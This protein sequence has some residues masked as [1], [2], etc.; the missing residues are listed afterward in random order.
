M[1][2]SDILRE[3]PLPD[4]WDK[5]VYNKGNKGGFKARIEYAKQKAQKIG[6]GSSRIAFIVEYQGRKTVLKIAKNNKGLAQNE[7]ERYMLY[8][9]QALHADGSVT[10]P[11]IDYDETADKPSWLHVE[12]APKLKNEQQ[13]EQLSGFNMEK[14]INYAGNLTHNRSLP[15]SHRMEFEKE[16]TQKVWENEESFSYDFVS[17]VGNCELHLPDLLRPANWGVFNNRP[18]II[19]LGLSEEIYTS[20]YSR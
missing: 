8:T 7:Q 12:Y 19:D 14:L 4:D 13:F 9:A 1:K 10:I 6:A 16:W 5:S 18:V 15:A 2:I 11:M 3:A 17:F 20:L